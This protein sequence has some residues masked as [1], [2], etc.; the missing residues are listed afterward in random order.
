MYNLIYLSN[1]IFIIVYWLQHIG[2]DSNIGLKLFTEI[3]PNFRLNSG[4]EAWLYV[5]QIFIFQRSVIILV[6]YEASDD[7]FDYQITIFQ[8]WEYL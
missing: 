1:N 7:S 6:V 3:F 2:L 5:R 8:E 4:K